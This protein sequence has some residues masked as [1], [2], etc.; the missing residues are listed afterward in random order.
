MPSTHASS[1][2]AIIGI[3]NMGGGMA[4]N[5]LSKGYAVHMHDIDPSKYAVYTRKGAVAQPNIAGAASKSVATIVCVVTAEQTQ[6]V[7]FGTGGVAASVP[8]GHTVLLCPTIAPLHVERFAAQ[9][10]QHGIHTIDAPMSGGPVRAA[11]GS[12]SLMVACADA[13]FDQHAKLLNDLSSK[14]FRI[15]Q[16][17]GDGARTKLVNNLLAGINLVG[18][19]EVLALAQRMGLD[20]ATTQSVISQSSGQS[21]IGSDRMQR[22]LAGDYAPR[23]H[24]TLLAKDTALAVQAASQLGPAPHT[25]PYPGPLG[26]HAA[27]VFAQALAA[28]LSGQDDSALFKLLQTTPVGK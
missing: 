28:G 22:A 17:P 6:Q 25:A 24:M 26:Q 9:L 14:L 19:A 27:Q 10:A 12:M 8:A 4:S 2:I 5:L 1:P 15:S 13:V 21:W 20:L 3:G 7:L 11:D 16:R 23:A 18:A